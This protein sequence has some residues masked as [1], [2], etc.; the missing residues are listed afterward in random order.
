[1]YQHVVEMCNIFVPGKQVFCTDDVDRDK[2]TQIKH[3]Q[4]GL[5]KT[6]PQRNSLPKT[7]PTYLDPSKAKAMNNTLAN[8]KANFC[9]F[10]S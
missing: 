10:S 4:S 6:K 5:N 3:D 1:M 7:P 9:N 8:P 2:K